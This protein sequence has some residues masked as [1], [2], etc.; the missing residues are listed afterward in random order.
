MLVDLVAV[1]LPENRRVG[2]KNSERSSVF[3]A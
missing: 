1:P 2:V 3:P